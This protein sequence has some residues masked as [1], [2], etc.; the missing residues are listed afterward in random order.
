M[1]AKEE[2]QEEQEGAGAFAAVAAAHGGGHGEGCYS[3]ADGDSSSAASDTP[4]ASTQMGLHGRDGRHR[5]VVQPGLSLQSRRAA[6]TEVA[7]DRREHW[8]NVAAQE[9]Q[10]NFAWF[11]GNYG[12][13]P[14][15]RTN[16]KRRNIMLQVKSQPAALIALCECTQDLEEELRAEGSEDQ[17]QRRKAAEQLE[18]PQMRG[19]EVLESRPRHKYMTTRGSEPSSLLIGV[20]ESVCDE[21]KVVDFWREEWADTSLKSAVADRGARSPTPASWSSK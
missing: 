5:K 2:D 8:S 7:P 3:E 1:E 10:A 12:S 20:R 14:Q 15:S 11:V 9:G 16:P 19:Q 18:D 4:N 17:P 13:L 21:L 6:Q